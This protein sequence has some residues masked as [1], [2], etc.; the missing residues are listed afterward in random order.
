VLSDED[1]RKELFSCLK[2]IRSIS[3]STALV[4]TDTHRFLRILKHSSKLQ[5]CYTQNFDGLEARAGL[6]NNLGFDDCEVVQL[7]GNLDSLRCTSCRY[8]TDWDEVDQM[9]LLSGKNI[10]CLQCTSIVEER[11]ARGARTNIHVGSLRPN[12]V[13]LHEYDDPSGERKAELIDQDSNLKVDMLLIIGT[14][15]AID[16]VKQVVGSTFIPAVRR[17]GGKVVY[18]SNVRPPKAFCKPKVDFIFEMDCDLWVR[19]LAECEPSLG[20]DVV[21]PARLPYFGL[22]TSP[23]AKTVT[24][25]IQAAESTLISIGDYSDIQYRLKDPHQVREDLG[26]FRVDGW[27]STSPL[28]C[29]L[30]LFDWGDTTKI[31]HSEYMN[32]NPSDASA[33]ERQGLVW[34]VGRRHTRVVI[35]H[36]PGNH[37]TLMVV[38]L[39]N[40]VVYYY[41]S[42]SG[43]DLEAA[44]MFLQAQM[45]RAGEEIGKD[46]STWNAPID[47]VG[48]PMY[49]RY[50]LTNHQR[51]LQQTNT[52][53]CG[54]YLLENARRISRGVSVH[55]KPIIA[56]DLRINFVELLVARSL[57]EASERS[58]LRGVSSVS[59]GAWQVGSEP[60][61]H[62]SK[63]APTRRRLKLEDIDA[64]C[65]GGDEGAASSSD[66]S[67]WSSELPIIKAKA[68][69]LFASSPVSPWHKYLESF[70]NCHIQ[71]SAT[72][73]GYAK[74]FRL[75]QMIAGFGCPEHFVALKSA[76]AQ[77]RLMRPHEV[78][79]TSIDV[80][81]HLYNV[82]LWTERMGLINAVLQRVARA[83]LV[84]L[85]N[86]GKD[87]YVDRSRDVE[88]QQR[89]AVVKA[90]KAMVIMIHP[91]MKGWD[92]SDNPSEVTAFTNVQR[93]LQRWR[94]EGS[95]WSLIQRRFDSLSLLV[96]APHHAR[97][98]CG[99]RSISSCS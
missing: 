21:R 56:E 55:K 87:L 32:F 7:H 78:V 4:E 46:Y 48:F 6:N 3:R 53:D 70:A 35:P 30:S 47:G 65:E 64:Q 93:N 44:I 84:S 60:G 77:Y 50:T 58:L 9:T 80:S 8:R 13:F 81:R 39:P 43:Y 85:V 31:L 68:A 14:S 95:I 57:F 69:A 97:V 20:L 40:R 41:N 25:A 33:G 36:N 51:S 98:M 38:D 72:K 52:S 74:A 76:I 61:S 45:K 66:E 91:H 49:R 99:L 67:T 54:I 82:A 12:I 96:L 1:A 26:C 79:K 75:L 2:N 62:L 94:R 17:S 28:M 16:G 23:K 11:R 92:T 63:T 71:R 34:P 73:M 15:L 83:H 42:L 24:E 5:R 10:P 37:W 19:K 27:L 90:V 29:I 88:M 18:V 22:D 89:S 86:E 59:P